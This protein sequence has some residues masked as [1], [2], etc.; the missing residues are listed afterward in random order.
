MGSF[1]HLREFEPSAGYCLRTKSVRFPQPRKTQELTNAD[2][3]DPS[4]DVAVATI[5][6]LVDGKLVLLQPTTTE[7]GELKYEMRIIAQNVETYALMRDHP[8]FAVDMQ[9]D[10]LPGSPSVGLT[11]DGVHG[12]DLRDSLWYFDGSD[13]RVWIDMQDVLASASADL[14]R[15]LPTPVKIPVDFYPLSALINKAIVFGIESELIQRRDTNFAFLRFATRVGSAT[16]LA[17][18]PGE[19]M[20]TLHR[21]IYSSLHCCVITWRSIIILQ[22]YTSATITNNC[23][24]SHMLWKYCCMKF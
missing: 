17:L 18:T 15:E 2:H 3:G 1:A 24:I 16:F 8:A 12:H 11:M 13:M 5:L 22:P 6:F 23:S 9:T 10:S 14:G 7:G 4:Q 19:C 20:L 21:H